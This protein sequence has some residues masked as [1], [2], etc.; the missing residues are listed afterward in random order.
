MAQQSSQTGPSLSLP[1]ETILKI[2]R[3]LS[4]PDLLRIARSCRTL[5]TVAA[6]RE[7]WDRL[8]LENTPYISEDGLNDTI[9]AA[10]RLTH[11]PNPII[12]LAKY[13]LMNQI[14]TVVITGSEY[15]TFETLVQIMF[16]HSIRSIHLRNCSSI[17]I[18][19]LSED[20][21]RTSGTRWD[22]STSY[23]FDYITNAIQNGAH[24]G[25]PSYR[26]RKT[27]LRLLDL[28]GCTLED[29]FHLSALQF[30]CVEESYYRIPWDAASP[31]P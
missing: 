8:V 26:F 14:R 29:D 5:R 24:K 12:S 13:T 22:L 27:E 6:S 28:T 31:T 11:F 30:L 2:F 1:P 17:N 7:L 15:L 25:K 4:S 9:A 23:N 20:L 3:Y 10:A 16:W 19:K 21:F 18:K